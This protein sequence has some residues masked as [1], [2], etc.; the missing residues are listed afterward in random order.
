VSDSSVKIGEKV[1]S[2]AGSFFHTST[3]SSPSRLSWYWYWNGFPAGTWTSIVQSE[4][5]TNPRGLRGVSS[6]R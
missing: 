2:S 3:V 1:R 6:T 4:F 5:L